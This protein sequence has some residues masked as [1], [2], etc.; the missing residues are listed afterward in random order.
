MMKLVKIGDNERLPGSLVEVTVMFTDIVGFTAMSEDMSAPQLEQ[1]LNHHFSLL[2]GC[3]EHTQG[4]VD[5]YIGDSLMAFWGAPDRQD[6]HA[7]RACR[8]AAEI[9]RTLEAD[10]D[11]REALGRE[12]VKLR[13]GIH[14]GPVVA[15]DIGGEA[16]V[17]YTVVGDTVNIAER[18]EELAREIESDGPDVVAVISR[19]TASRTTGALRADSLGRHVLHGR[20]GT[21]EALVL[22]LDS[23]SDA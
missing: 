21:I 1:F 18:L 10:N 16:R 17:N 20:R 9:A 15:G 11:A 13:I 3:V 5:K 6:D 4:T 14:S 7:L 8:T 22:D 23:V 12:R 2:N 19:Q